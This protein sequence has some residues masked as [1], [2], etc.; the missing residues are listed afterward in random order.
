MPDPIDDDNVTGSGKKRSS[1]KT[2][3]PSIDMLIETMSGTSRAKKAHYDSKVTFVEKYTMKDCM[4]VL[5]TM[6]VSSEQY[7]LAAEKLVQGKEWHTFFLISP[8][9]RQLN[10]V[11]DLK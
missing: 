4:M 9:D 2:S 3:I 8:P 11:N 1:L 10:W 6:P 7:G 5:A